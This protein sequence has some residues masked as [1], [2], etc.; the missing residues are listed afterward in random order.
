MKRPTLIAVSIG[1][2]VELNHDSI[3]WIVCISQW[4]SL[5]ASKHFVSWYYEKVKFLTLLKQNIF[6]SLKN[7]RIKKSVLLNA[8][9]ILPRLNS[10]EPSHF[11]SSFRKS[12]SRI[13]EHNS[14][15][16][17]I[18][19][20]SNFL[21]SSWTPLPPTS[22]LSR[23]ASTTTTP[24]QCSTTETM[25]T[26]G[27]WPWSTGETASSSLRSRTLRTRDSGVCLENSGYF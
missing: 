3:G 27:W 18:P 26:L 22:A 11:Q 17:Q 14:K 21:F 8:N 4:S 1:T 5:T 7:P 15:L 2:E 13:L 23:A 10:N 24:I 6:S 25:A 9:F 12:Q 20:I 16:K 19:N